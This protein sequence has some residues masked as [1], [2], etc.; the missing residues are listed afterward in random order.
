[1]TGRDWVWALGAGLCGSLLPACSTTTAVR[2]AGRP[3]AQVS[4]RADRPPAAEDQPPPPATAPSAV[5]PPAAANPAAGAAKET[6]G[7]EAPT[8][9]AQNVQPIPGREAAPAKGAQ[10]ILAGHSR[11]A[12]P[13]EPLLPPTKVGEA[14]VKA[15]AEPPLL[16]AL[17]CYLDKRPAEAVH[18]L[19]GY[20]KTSQDLLLCLLPLTARL[21]E[22][23]LRDAK[24]QEVA[25]LLDQLDGLAV[26]L[27]TRAP[28][29]IDKLYY[30][31]L[32]KSFGD[33]DPL[34]EDHV[35]HPDDE[36][37]V[38]VE[39]RNFGSVKREAGPGQSTYVTP[40]YSSAVIY[41]Q[42]D[43]KVWRQDIVF[44]R[45]KPD[46]SRSLRHDY[47]DHCRFWVP[48]IPPGTYKLKILVRDE[49]TQR[50]TQESLK[51]CVGTLTRGS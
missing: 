40:L 31:R 41:D 24:P 27:R 15:P 16:T 12:D 44:L 10:T 25:V 23:G 28:L 46:E 42:D 45:D 20:D 43:K 38:Y 8:E 49:T 48:K 50:T 18:L 34:P 7:G 30:C 37:H 32:I 35:F 5:P 11:E 36:V 51:F 22:G 21:T 9:L 6:K 47:F 17:R 3:P 1:M 19:E 2:P 33:Y 13:F 4:S 39:L 29:T 26:P 14:E